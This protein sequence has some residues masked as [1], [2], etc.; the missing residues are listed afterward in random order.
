VS[1][2]VGEG[3]GEQ[4][5]SFLAET[6]FVDLQ[7]GGD[8]MEGLMARKGEEKKA[9]RTLKRN[10]AKR[11]SDRKGRRIAGGLR[12][13][14][15]GRHKTAAAREK[16]VEPPAPVTG[17]IPG[18]KTSKKAIFSKRCAEGESDKG[19]AGGLLEDGRG[20]HH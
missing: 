4:S 18:L 2:G 16:N 6:L 7:H 14:E 11:R 10:G 12:A 19:K 8:E 3:K 1:T 15:D 13:S 5:F 17:R 20:S 9:D